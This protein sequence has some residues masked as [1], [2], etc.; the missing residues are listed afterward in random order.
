MKNILKNW[1]HDEVILK[2]KDILNLKI[3]RVMH[4]AEKAKYKEQDEEKAKRY[5]DEV[6]KLVNRQFELSE[7]FSC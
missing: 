1:I 7:K 3:R 2:R 4:L 6:I 5:M